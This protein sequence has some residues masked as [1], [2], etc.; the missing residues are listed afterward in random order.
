MTQQQVLCWEAPCRN[1]QLCL[2]QCLPTY[3]HAW[4]ALPAGLCHSLQC[5]DGSA[6]CAF[7]FPK[8]F[9]FWLFCD[10]LF[11]IFC[12]C[13]R[14]SIRNVGK[15]YKNTSNGVSLPCCF[16][17]SRKEHCQITEVWL[18]FALSNSDPFPSH[19][20]LPRKIFACI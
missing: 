6:W 11:L 18:S 5:K 16:V 1:S 15:V 7:P 8:L 14:V 13:V 3:C 20:K 2:E 19:I 4:A 10:F 17:N 9:I 12:V